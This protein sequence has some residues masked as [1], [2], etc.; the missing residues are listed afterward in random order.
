[1][2][3]KEIKLYRKRED[4]VIASQS[5]NRGN[6]RGE[7]EYQDALDQY[8]GE[9]YCDTYSEAKESEYKKPQAKIKF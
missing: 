2:E 4:G 1:M 3:N 6:F 9:G 7:D 8:Y 5:V